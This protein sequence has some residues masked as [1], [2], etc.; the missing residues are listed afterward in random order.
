MDAL[1]GANVHEHVARAMYYL[2]VHLLFASIVASAAWAL[3][4][5]LRASA[6][7]KY[8]VWVATVFNFVLPSGALIDSLGAPHLTW[9][10][11]LSAIGAP[12]WDVTQGR[13]AVIL[14]AVWMTG[15]FCMVGR[16]LSRI[17]RERREAQRMAPL[18]NV[19]LTSNFLADGIPVS[20]DDRQMGPAV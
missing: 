3:T 14:G 19:G 8:W 6:T 11:P 4:S 9:A 20:F 2:S 10:S 17:C 13:A 15:G 7:T 1:E 5:V 16:L 12:V 18:S